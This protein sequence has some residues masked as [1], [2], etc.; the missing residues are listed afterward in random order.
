M[1]GEIKFDQFFGPASL[2]G[3]VVGTAYLLLIVMRTVEI[4]VGYGAVVIVGLPL[5]LTTGAFKRFGAG[6]VLSLA[7]IPLTVVTFL[8]GAG[9]DASVGG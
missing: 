2:F 4:S 6:L 3:V 7:V 9:V 5:M 8:V 1:K